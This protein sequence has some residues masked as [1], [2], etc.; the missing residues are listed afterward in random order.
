MCCCRLSSTGHP[1][2]SLTWLTKVLKLR[3]S[4]ESLLF[5]QLVLDKST[6][7]FPKLLVFARQAKGFPSMVVAL[8]LNAQRGF[9]R[10]CTFAGGRDAK[11]KPLNGTVEFVSSKG[12]STF[13]EGATDVPLDKVYLPRGPS[14]LII[15]Y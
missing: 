6:S 12:E 8:N 3:T 5:G 1:A 2:S 4:K 11:G 10:D 7:M 14:L 13:I 15:S 9:S